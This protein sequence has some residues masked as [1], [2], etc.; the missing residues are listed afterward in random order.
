MITYPVGFWNPISQGGGGG[1]DP[2]ANNV[3][4][5]LKA[6]Q[7]NLVT[8]TTT[9]ANFTVPAVN[10]TATINVDSSSFAA[11][12]R[13]IR[14]GNSAGNYIITAVPN[15]SQITIR[16]CGGSDNAVASTVVN[17]GATIALSIIDSSVS[18]KAI[19]AFESSQL[20][21]AQSK[22]NGSSIL[23]DSGYLETNLP[24]TLNNYTLE[25]WF[26]LL[27]T[28]QHTIFSGA[29][30]GDS[31]FVIYGNE[32]RIGRT[33]VA[34]DIVH[35]VSMPVN[36]WIH[37]AFSRTGNTQRIFLNGNQILSTSYSNAINITSLARIGI[38]RDNFAPPGILTRQAR[39]YF[40]HTRLTSTGRYTANFNPETDTFLNI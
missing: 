22:Y 18:P 4:L 33:N 10:S 37:I 13:A 5:F 24:L 2:H 36:S 15:G 16:N 26:Y 38:T 12:G 28:R 29:S 20:S 19:S 9:T 6:D 7:S 17:S 8:N 34:W 32:W 25:G 14:I 40:S 35:S 27:E 3:V 1:I 31:D 30:I 21:T 39:A 23:F 11:A